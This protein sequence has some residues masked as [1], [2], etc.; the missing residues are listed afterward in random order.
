MLHADFALHIFK[1]FTGNIFDFQIHNV[2]DTFCARK[3]RKYGVHLHGDFINRAGELPCIGHK[4]TQT[5]D[6]KAFKY[7]QD[8]AKHGC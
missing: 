1:L 7:T 2:K 6:I 5:S 8:S 4:N 3:C